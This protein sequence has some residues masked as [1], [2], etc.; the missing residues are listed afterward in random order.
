MLL[1]TAIELCPH[2]DFVPAIV[3]VGAVEDQLR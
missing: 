1:D 2:G 3:L